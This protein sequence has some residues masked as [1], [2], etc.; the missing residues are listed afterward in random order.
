M[1]VPSAQPLILNGNEKR[2][3]DGPATVVCIFGRAFVMYWCNGCDN[4]THVHKEKGTGKTYTEMRQ[5]HIKLLHGGES[6]TF[7]G[8]GEVWDV[9][10]GEC[11]ATVVLEK[12]SVK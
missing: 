10:A 12:Q 11:G 6:V 1:G 3:F 4:P 2:S 7:D 8:G 5:L 9:S